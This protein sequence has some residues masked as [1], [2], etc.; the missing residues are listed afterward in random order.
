LLERLGPTFIKIGQF[1][2][3]RP[4]LI[5]QAYCDELL[6][7]LDRVP[8]FP[9]AGAQQILRAELGDDPEKLFRSIDTTP[10]AA[11]SLAQVHAAVTHSGVEVAVKILRPRIEEQVK[12]DLRRARLLAG[13]LDRSGVT[14]VVS[15]REV[16]A[17]LTVWLGEE[18]DL[19]HELGNLTRLRQLS[20]SATERIPKPF[21]RLCTTHVLT[22]EYIHGVR[23]T[24]LIG[25][26]YTPPGIDR[27]ALAANLLRSTLNQIFRY[28]FFH[29]DLHPGNL[30]ALEDNAI[31]YVDFGLCDH[32]DDTV[33]NR[34][35][36]YLSAV[37]NHDID[38]MFRALSEILVAS[39]DTDL[40]AFRTDFY[41]ETGAY[42]DRIEHARGDRQAQA[43]DRQSPI[44]EWLIRVMRSARRHRLRFPPRILS[45]YRA[46]LTAETVARRLGG[47]ADLRRAGREFFEELRWEELFRES[48]LE[49][50]Q[51]IFLSIVSLLRD[52][53]GQLQQILSDTAEG[54]L[55]LTVSVTESAQARRRKD[56]RAKLLAAAVLSAA[57]SILLAQAGGTSVFGV[58]AAW[59]LG[60]LLVALYGTVL[61]QWRRLR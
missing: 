53:P 36:R 41:A 21:P 32:L 2:A 59:P 7:L 24:E 51:P 33:R 55:A 27:A 58:R 17:E 42:F 43:S 5:P 9:W 13:L 48:S 20:Q 47:K 4:D 31:G 39:D 37:Y 1:L 50:L 40:Q 61:W 46:L 30:I 54:R 8:P 52:G 44:A 26:R 25:S 57:A 22:V 14:L 56:H 11:G 12:R 10:V 29:A 15:P 35:L 19:N 45:L 38:G 3:L 34:Q 49:R 6:N 28:R 60:A 16:I 23:F 18:I